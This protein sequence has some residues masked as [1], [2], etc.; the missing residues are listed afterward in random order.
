[1]PTNYK[2]RADFKK[3]L[4]IERNGPVDINRIPEIE[5][6]FQM[7]I[8]I[9]G[10][11]TYT[12][13]KQ[14]LKEITIKL[15][16]GHYELSKIHGSNTIR[17]QM[18]HCCDEPKRHVIF[19]AF[20]AEKR[21]EFC[22]GVKTWEDS[23]EGKKP[24]DFLERQ[25]D[26]SKA[27]YWFLDSKKLEKEKEDRDLMVLHK[28]YSDMAKTLY[29]KTDGLVDL[30]RNSTIKNATKMAV[31]LRM[32]SY[33]GS[34]DAIT[35]MEFQ[36]LEEATTGALIYKLMADCGDT[37]Y[38]DVNSMYPSRLNSM[39]IPIRVGEFNSNAQAYLDK[40]KE[41]PTKTNFMV[42]L[43]LKI[44]GQ[45]AYF[46]FNPLHKYTNFD[47]QSA[48]TLGLNIEVIND[49]EANALFYPLSSCITGSK[50][51]DG[52][53]TE[54]YGLKRDNVKGAKQLLNILWG[55][56]CQQTKHKHYIRNA[57][58]EIDIA[59]GVFHSI[60]TTA[61]G[62]EEIKMTDDKI[63]YITNLARLKPF[64]LSSARYRMVQLLKDIPIE[65]VVRIHTDGVHLKTMNDKLRVGVNMGEMKFTRITEPE[66]KPKIDFY[67]KN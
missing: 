62:E 29:E 4:N 17:K 14:Y 61:L 22:D 11:H 55:A 9:T 7:K 35:L 53:I 38:Y 8:N 48:L 67:Q 6:T 31:Y 63:P 24:Y 21:A 65:N 28:K 64:L 13:G 46:R 26:H 44:T 27:E 25:P 2:T 5:E 18:L 30:Y 56:L 52:Y 3:S 19:R 49:G 43:R 40:I 23:T 42:I 41:D 47:I 45:N 37:F 36:W 58:H 12:S 57:N 54:M 50:L 16:S 51:F 32:R 33:T 10:D 60:R 1:M 34:M 15:S 59:E 20:W 39:F 66:K